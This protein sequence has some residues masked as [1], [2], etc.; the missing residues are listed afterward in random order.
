M[1][2]GC[3][4]HKDTYANN[5]RF[6]FRADSDCQMLI[7]LKGP[8]EFQIGFDVIC[9]GADDA[10][11]PKYFKRKGSGSYRS[12]F[13]VM[14]FELTGGTYDVVPSTFYPGQQSSFF[15]KFQATIPFKVSRLQ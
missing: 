4:N 5:P 1:A 13:V 10:K 12:G 6:Q 8:K 7:E 14:A 15:M 9:T 11:S 3:G 2:G